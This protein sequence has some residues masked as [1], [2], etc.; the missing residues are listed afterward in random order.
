MAPTHGDQHQLQ[1]KL[2]KRAGHIILKADFTT[3]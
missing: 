1:N 3:L 2:Q